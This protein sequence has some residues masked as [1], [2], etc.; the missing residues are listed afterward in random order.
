[1]VLQ[2]ERI[3][4]DKI[5]NKRKYNFFFK[6]VLLSDTNLIHHYTE[7]RNPDAIRRILDVGCWIFDFGFK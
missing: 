3:I 5:I 7:F 1:M 2:P 6:G 4:K